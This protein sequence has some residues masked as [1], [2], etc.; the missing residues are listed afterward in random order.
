MGAKSERKVND[1]YQMTRYV[2]GIGRPIMFRIKSIR[3][4]SDDQPYYGIVFLS[5]D[6]T[7]KSEAIQV[8]ELFFE[9]NNAKKIASLNSSEYT[10]IRILFD[11]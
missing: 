3:Y 10:L 8:I 7:I 5:E 9:T 11:S 1:I 2:D 4:D 6:F